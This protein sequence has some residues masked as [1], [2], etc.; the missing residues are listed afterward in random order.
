MSKKIINILVITAI[1]LTI[2]CYFYFS[3]KNIYEEKTD[4][5]AWLITS[6][7]S[8]YGSQ[9]MSFVI[10]DVDKAGLVLID[11]GYKNSEENVSTIY[12]IIQE[13]NNKVDAWIITHFDC[14][15]VGAL[16][17]ILENHP[18]V[19]INT[20][21]CPDVFDIDLEY[22][23]KDAPWEEETWE[24][25][26]EF[27]NMNLQNLVKVH[28]GD[29]YND[30][31]GLKMKVLSTYEPWMKDEY[32]NLFNSGAMIFKLYSKNE[33][34]LFC[35]D[36]NTVKNCN[37]LIEHYKDDLKSNYLQIAHHGNNN[38]IDEF[39]DLV[40]PQIAFF[41]S[42]KFII[43][44]TVDWYTADELIVKLKNKG[45]ECRTFETSPNQIMMR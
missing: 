6:W 18:E 23:K 21:Y 10:E 42:P 44:G 39:Y 15:H 30:I 16:V 26:Q 40:N 11:G 1:I 19:E 4:D 3:R 12:N 17:S 41:C 22:L 7:G 2:F 32:T 13:Y 38:Y 25:Y 34:M 45:I 31:I 20:I 33:S 27:C 5:K 8:Y 9:M 35:S 14:D 28:I 36:A 37:Y 29:E 43:E 24:V